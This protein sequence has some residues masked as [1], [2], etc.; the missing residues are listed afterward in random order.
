MIKPRIKS[1]DI[2]RLEGAAARSV[3]IMVKI[4]DSKFQIPNP[5]SKHKMLGGV[6]W[7]LS[8]LRFLGLA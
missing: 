1:R 6:C 2:N 5:K 4:P 7:R 8:E 3:G